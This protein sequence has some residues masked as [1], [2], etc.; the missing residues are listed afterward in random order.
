MVWKEA[1]IVQ[2]G[3]LAQ[4]TSMTGQTE[5][6]HKTEQM[7]LVF[8]QTFEAGNPRIHDI[9][10]NFKVFASVYGGSV[11]LGCDATSPGFRLLTFRQKRNGHIYEGHNV[12]EECSG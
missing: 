7:H 2:S 10:A 1:T 11:L 12:H 9:N 3:L 6:N 8:R 5:G 4:Y